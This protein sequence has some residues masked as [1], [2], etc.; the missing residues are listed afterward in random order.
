MADPSAAR[1]TLREL[2]SPVDCHGSGNAAVRGIATDSRHVQPGDVFF[3]RP[4]LR[5]DGRRFMQQAVAN[6]AVAVVSAADPLATAMHS[7]GVDVVNGVAVIAVDDINAV[8]G[9]AS[10]RLHGSPCQSLRLFGVTGTNGKTTVAYLLAHVL[11]KLGGCG[12]IGTLGAGRPGEIIPTTHTTPEV[13][14]TNELLAKFAASRTQYVAM[15]VSSHGIAQGRICGLVFDTAIFTNFSQ[16]H[17]DYHGDMESYWSAKE[18]LFKSEGL[19][20]AIVNL[21]DPCATRIKAPAG[22]Q[23]LGYSAHAGVAGAEL[24]VTV[25]ERSEGPELRLQINGAWGPAELESRL[26]GDFNAYNLAAVILALLNAGVSL[27]DACRYLSLADAP[28]GRMQ[29]LGGGDRPVAVVDYAHTPAAL[30]VAL[31]ASATLLDERLSR[32]RLWCVFGCGGER[33]KDKRAQMGAIAAGLA[34]RVMITDDNPRAEPS[35]EIIADILAGIAK[36][37]DVM[38]EADRAQ[39]IHRVISAAKV[40]DV[41]LV[42]GKGHETSQERAGVRTLFSDVQ[43]VRRALCA[44]TSIGHTSA[45]WNYPGLAS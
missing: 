4:G 39:A 38:V 29:W 19:G 5:V 26:V 1:L 6:G 17:L 3:A 20:T 15:E 30:R 37:T 7:S 13:T 2:L 21:D 22:G 44:Y 32:G 34:D 11:D 24:T 35:A 45:D 33:D 9:I 28:P 8:L 31:R 14:R 25:D 10:A 42:A 43:E 16:D 27:A 23:L 36:P 18:G 40:G 12:L 41:I